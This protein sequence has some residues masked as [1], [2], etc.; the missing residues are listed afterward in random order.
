MVFPMMCLTYEGIK[1]H[2]LYINPK[3]MDSWKI[4]AFFLVI[5]PLPSHF[6]KWV[7]GK[8][9]HFLFLSPSNRLLKVQGCQLLTYTSIKPP[10]LCSFPLLIFSLVPCDQ[11]SRPSPK[12]CRDTAGFTQRYCRMKP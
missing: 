4:I 7:G 11:S 5:F 1:I 6:E 10:F 3:F 12:S 2:L 9:K 8:F